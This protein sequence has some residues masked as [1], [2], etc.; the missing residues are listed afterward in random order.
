M[1]VWYHILVLICFVGT[2]RVT[3]RRRAGSLT[4]GQSYNLTCTVILNGT[5][6]SPTIEWLGPN[7]NS[8]M[9]NR[10]MVNNSTYERTLLFSSLRTS[11]GGQYTCQAVLGQTSA[12]A[13]TKILLQGTY[14]KSITLCIYCKMCYHCTLFANKYWLFVLREWNARKIQR[15]S[16]N[17]N[18]KHSEC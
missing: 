10:V 6:G 9:E 2:M 5:T 13:S 3:I 12:M 7:N 15:S 18:P 11:H 4:P 16:W 1:I 17:L 14:V 8:T